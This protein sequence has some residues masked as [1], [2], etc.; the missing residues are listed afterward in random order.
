MP[1]APRVIAY[2]LPCVVLCAAISGCGSPPEN[3]VV[4]PRTFQVAYQSAV[5]GEIEPCG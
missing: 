4:G 3:L 5:H 2:A 1:N